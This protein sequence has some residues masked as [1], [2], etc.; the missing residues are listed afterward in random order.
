MRSANSMRFLSIGVAAALGLTFSATASGQSNPGPQSSTQQQ[1]A[2]NSGGAT[3]ST[4]GATPTLSA[5][6]RSINDAY[7]KSKTAATLEDYG[8]IVSMCQ[9][10]IDHEATP[11]RTA[12]AKK[13]SDWAGA[14]VHN[15][16][17][18]KEVANGDEKAAL[19]E[20]EAAVAL[21]SNFWRALHNRGVSRA[22]AGNA[23]DALA[24]FEA[25]IKLNPNYANAWFN[26]G[27]LKYAKNDF[28]GALDDYNQAIQLQPNDPGF[29]SSRGHAKYHLGRANEAMI[30]YNR[31]V[32]LEPN[33][34]AWLVD[35]G[36]AFR[37]QAQYQA[38]AADYRDAIR[39]NPKFGRAYLGAAW[40]MATCPDARFRES[41]KAISAAQKAIDLDGDKDY[42]YLDTLAAAQANAGQF[43][44]AKKS[45]NQALAIVPPKEM[46]QVRQR[47]D[48]YESGRAYREGAPPEQVRAA[49]AIRTQ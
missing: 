13:L 28:A 24:D 45:V 31:A 38:A 26:R 41:D 5:G 20:F 18:E 15:K 7:Q 46:P 25:V 48:L 44:A 34:A 27:E 8:Q 35:R 40:L 37:E 6:D 14:R 29:Y 17:G 33:N 11:E 3:K 23:K 30:D 21:D 22:G 16:Q 2:A 47:S 49:A 32:Q 10:G 39:L 43:D 1:P 19:K 9:A 42:R 36:E 4:P 12:Y